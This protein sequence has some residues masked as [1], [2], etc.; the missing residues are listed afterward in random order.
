M[1]EGGGS[2]ERRPGEGEGG[3]KAIRDGG[4]GAPV[5]GV[6]EGLCG[7]QFVG[8]LVLVVWGCGPVVM[9]AAASGV[10]GG[11]EGGARRCRVTSAV[12]GLR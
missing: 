5:S 11:V 12:A 6:D 3:R 2:K 8:V 7:V 9:S 10:E 4:H 1:E